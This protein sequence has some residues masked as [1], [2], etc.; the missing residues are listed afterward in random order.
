MKYLN[1][2][3]QYLITIYYLK[4][5][6]ILWRIYYYFKP[7]ILID[8]KIEDITT[9][10]CV[11]TKFLIKSDSILKKNK[12]VFLNEPIC[13]SSNHKLEEIKL[14]KLW[15]YNLNYFDFINSNLNNTKEKFA[16]EFLERWLKEVKSPKYIGNDPYPTSLR[17]VNWIKFYL[18]RKQISKSIKL[19]LLKQTDYLY[20]NLE[21]HLLGNHILS[22]AK[23]L[24]F[25]G[26]FF[27]GPNSKKWKKKG[28]HIYKKQLKDQILQDGGH[29]EKSPM[30]HAI[31]LEDIL[32]IINL[33]NNNSILPSDFREQL[34]ETAEKMLSWLN[35][36]SYK[37]GET[38]NFNDNANNISHNIIDISK[39]AKRLGIK[40][41]KPIKKNSELTIKDLNHS[42]FFRID[43]PNVTSFL[44]VG[45][46]GAPYIAG[47]A[48]A[49][50][51]SFET[52]FFDQR[53]FVNLGVSTYETSKRRLLERSTKSHNTVE[54]NKKNSSDVWSSFRVASRAS[55]FDLKTKKLK[56]KF[57]ISCKHDGY[58]K[59]IKKNHHCRSWIFEDNK[60][61]I[62]DEITSHK[63][64][65]IASFILHPNIEVININNEHYY[66]LKIKNKNKKIKFIVVDG[67]SIVE[68]KLY[69]PEFGILKETKSI[70]IKLLKG[71]SEVNLTW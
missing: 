17:I 40:T 34:I 35:I 66:I 24:I 63:S 55:T 53:F 58:N 9:K 31:I 32:D 28:I 33:S 48:H 18:H 12:F 5:S 27:S 8:I 56:R 1:R 29:F 62:K 13:I 14:N 45:S 71:K 52:S 38:P 23:A 57:I 2:L 43:Q 68:K 10:L 54:I 6:Q 59:I 65:A 20:H 37:N 67:E 64:Y 7:R 60:I 22:N 15:L 21:W 46:I 25:S 70:S 51:L 26:M 41:F 42:G 3:N 30:Y 11:R 69:A 16:L 47:H 50:T 4:L 44:D 61:V 19:S 36:M 49:D 39:Y